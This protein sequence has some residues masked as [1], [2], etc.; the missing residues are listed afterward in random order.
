VTIGLIVLVVALIM[1]YAGISDRSFARLLLGDASRRGSGDRKTGAPAAAT[2]GSAG[3]SLA[4]QII[5]RPYQGT[6]RR[7]NWESDNAVDVRLPL[8]TPVYAVASGTIGPQFGPLPGAAGDPRLAGLRLHLVGAGTEFYYAHL[9]R[10]APGI[11]PGVHVEAGQL[12]GYSGQAAGVP[13]LHFAVRD[14]SPFEWVAAAVG[15][16]REAVGLR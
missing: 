4:G 8:G 14:G 6:H 3:G 10:F 11:A 15:R 9:S 16:L 12:L 13:H 5:G 2:G 1:L 7:G